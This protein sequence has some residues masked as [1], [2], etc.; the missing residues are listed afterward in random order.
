MERV[1][2]N[3]V[4][5]VPTDDIDPVRVSYDPYNDNPYNRLSSW[6]NQALELTEINRKEYGFKI[7][8]KDNV[9]GLLEGEDNQITF[10][11]ATA[12]DNMIHFHTHPNNRSPIEGRNIDLPNLYPSPGDIEHVLI[13]QKSAEAWNLD[14]A[15]S[16]VL[17]MVRRG[18][19]SPDTWITI[20]RSR[21]AKSGSKNENKRQNNNTLMRLNEEIFNKAY[22]LEPD[23]LNHSNGLSAFDDDARDRLSSSAAKQIID[24]F[25]HYED[26]RQRL[27]DEIYDLKIMDKASGFIEIDYFIEKPNVTLDIRRQD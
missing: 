8:R 7:D 2:V 13:R 10:P 20:A 18:E 24:D 16:H 12:K 6:I 11:P 27:L 14:V 21:I 9:L 1:P 25:R 5:D 4:S 23:E 19:Y 26:T 3:R 22:G 15:V 17:S